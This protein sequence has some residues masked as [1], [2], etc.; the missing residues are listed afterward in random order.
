MTSWQLSPRILGAIRAA[1]VAL[2]AAAAAVHLGV[3][4][5]HFEGI[6]TNHRVPGT[7]FT[8]SRDIY[9]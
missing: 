2:S 9:V 4:P 7:F 5:E 8:A 6:G 1:V 3:A